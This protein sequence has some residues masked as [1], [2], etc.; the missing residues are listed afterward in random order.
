MRETNR[1]QMTW[2]MSA[3]HPERKKRK[4]TLREMGEEWVVADGSCGDRMGKVRMP[5]MKLARDAMIDVVRNP[6]EGMKKKMAIRTPNDPPMVS[7]A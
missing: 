7:I 2:N 4:S 5:A 1:V 6:N 3:A